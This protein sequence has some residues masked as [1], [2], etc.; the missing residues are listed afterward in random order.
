M[1]AAPVV[2]AYAR[3]SP[4]KEGGKGS[5]LGVDNQHEAIAGEER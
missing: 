1:S 2:F 5:T 3:K 4:Y